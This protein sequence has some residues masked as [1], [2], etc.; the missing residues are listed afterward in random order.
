MVA[1]IDKTWIVSSQSPAQ[2]VL[3]AEQP[4]DE[5]L[6]IKGPYNVH[7]RDQVVTY[8]TLLGKIRPEQ[9]DD[10]DPDGMIIQLFAR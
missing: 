3:L 2:K 6:V 8:F 9:V 7:L 4:L 10:T 5:P 1:S